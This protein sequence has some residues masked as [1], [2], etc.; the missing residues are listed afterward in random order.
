MHETDF[1]RSLRLRSCCFTGH[2]PE[3]L[4]LSEAEI[5]RALKE[6]IL[7][8]IADGCDRFFTGMARGVDLWAAQE[9][10]S[11]R[12][13]YP[14]LQL[15]AAIPYE[16]FEAQWSPYWQQL[17]RSV[18][19]ACGDV[20]IFRKDFSYDSFQTR[21]RYMVD[22]CGRVIAVYNGTPGGTRNTVLYARELERKVFL[23]WDRIEEE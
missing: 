19:A 20:H 12:S 6:E 15:A 3:K 1:D 2:R 22:H 16:G 7:R 8:A 10:V 9:V 23:I 18:L 5:R 14:Q 4:N 11:L 21:N 13:Q 17:Y